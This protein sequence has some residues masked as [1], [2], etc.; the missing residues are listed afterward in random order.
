VIRVH[1]PEAADARSLS[2]R[3]Y[4]QLRELIVTLDLA[5]GAVVNERELMDRLGVGRT[6]IREALRTLARQRLVEVYPRRGIFVAPVHVGDLAALSEVR[7]VLEVFAARLAA[8]RSTAANRATT[9]RLLDELERPEHDERSL[10]YLD[11]RIHRHIHRSAANPF[12]EE[13]L[14][15]YYFLTLRIWMVALERV[16]RLESAIQEHRELLQAIL[17]GDAD[18]AE[19]AMRRHVRGFEH[20][21]RAVL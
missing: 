2:D 15:E 8:Q 18:R 19:T 7:E 21:V 13:S 16:A 9:S 3:A 11:Q 5:P 17:A 6:P 12:L 10:I 4:F 1:Q 20:A 14:E